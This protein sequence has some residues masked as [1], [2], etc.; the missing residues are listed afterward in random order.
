MGAA[1]VVAHRI[2]HGGERYRDAVVVDARAE[3]DLRALAERIPVAEIGH[4]LEHQS[5]MR[6]L[7]GTADMRAA[8]ARGGPALDVYLHRLRAGI[9]AMA[10]AMDGLDA[11][12]F[13][14]G[15]GEGSARVRAETVR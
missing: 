7:A 9:A 10:A 11:L 1:D 15:V 4:A 5:G 14:A 2:V 13:T 8:V 12:V 3:A 6:G